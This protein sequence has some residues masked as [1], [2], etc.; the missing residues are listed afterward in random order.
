MLT[1]LHYYLYILGFRPEITVRKK[2]GQKRNKCIL[3]P[4]KHTE[5]TEPRLQTYN[6]FVLM[7]DIF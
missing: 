2:S 7:N 3:R 1:A 4:T 5:T 6:T